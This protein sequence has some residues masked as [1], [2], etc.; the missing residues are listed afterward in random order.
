MVKVMGKRRIFD[1]DADW[2]PAKG[3]IFTMKR[4]TTGTREAKRD[5]I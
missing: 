2:V 4:Q 3:R 5:T 1:E